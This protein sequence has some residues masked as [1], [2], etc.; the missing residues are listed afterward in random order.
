M[1][2]RTFVRPPGLAPPTLPKS[3]PQLLTAQYFTYKSLG[4]RI[5]HENFP[6]LYENEEFRGGR[7][8]G[9]PALPATHPAAIAIRCTTPCIPWTSLI[10]AVRSP[11]SW[12]NDE[13]VLPPLD[14]RLGNPHDVARQQPRGASV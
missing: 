8:R 7:G 10:V 5:L 6:Y 9:V 11:L 2:C 1:S 3:L 13:R 12:K 4:C 14:A